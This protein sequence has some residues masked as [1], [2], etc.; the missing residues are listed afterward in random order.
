MNLRKT[1][2]TNFRL[3]WLLSAGMFIGAW[4]LPMDVKGSTML[5]GTILVIFVTHDY[6]CSPFEMLWF[7]GFYTAVFAIAATVLGWILQCIAS[8]IVTEFRNSSKKQE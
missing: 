2:P 5:V 8:L 3:W 6:I 7:I 1:Y 4:F